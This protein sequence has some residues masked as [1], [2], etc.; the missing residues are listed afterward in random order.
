[1]TLTAIDVWI[2]HNTLVAEICFKD[3]NQV[4]MFQ[5]ERPI[6]IWEKL[7]DEEAVTRLY[8][9]ELAMFYGGVFCEEIRFDLG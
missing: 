8:L 5:H 6:K 2:E 7:L 4:V 3:G 9:F 1:M